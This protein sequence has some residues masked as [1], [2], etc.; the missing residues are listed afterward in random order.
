[1]KESSEPMLTSV[2]ASFSP[3]G[4]HLVSVGDT[5]EVFLYSVDPVSGE[6]AQITTY[7]GELRRWLITAK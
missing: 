3:D 1:M 4:R 7:N 6:L 2:S 5:P